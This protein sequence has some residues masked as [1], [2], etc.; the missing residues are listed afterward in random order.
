[1]KIDRVLAARVLAKWNGWSEEKFAECAR[2]NELY[3]VGPNACMFALDKVGNT[4]PAYRLVDTQF[5]KNLTVALP[6]SCMST[7]MMSFLWSLELA[8]LPNEGGGFEIEVINDVGK[9]S[10]SQ[11]IRFGLAQFNSVPQLLSAIDETLKTETPERINKVRS[12]YSWSVN[13]GK[14]LRLQDAYIKG[15]LR[16]IIS[17][18]K[19]RETLT[20][21]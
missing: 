15:A 13:R 11:E 19:A 6:L 17:R 16:K 4:I 7:K 18:N 5:P 2:N 3:R 9:T 21:Y 1:V 10:I 20:S 8:R 12:R 14:T